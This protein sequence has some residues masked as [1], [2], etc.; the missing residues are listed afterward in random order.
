LRSNGNTGI[1]LHSNNRENTNWRF[2]H[3]Q[4]I[5][6][7]IQGTAS[8]KLRINQQWYH[9]IEN[10]WATQQAITQKVTFIHDRWALKIYYSQFEVV[11][12]LFRVLNLKKGELSFQ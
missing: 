6:Q 5:T 8:A 7:K 10:R 4:T 12:S 9:Q 1:V 11:S 2:F 3:Q